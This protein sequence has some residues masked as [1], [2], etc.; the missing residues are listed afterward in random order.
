MVLIL[1][2]MIGRRESSEGLQFDL[3]VLKSNKCIN[4]PLIHVLPSIWPIGI[5]ISCDLAPL[6]SFPTFNLTY[7][8]WNEPPMRC[9]NWRTSS[10]QFDLLVLKLP[11]WKAHWGWTGLLQFDLLVLKCRWNRRLVWGFQSFNLTYWYWNVLVATGAHVQGPL[12]FDLLVLKSPW[13]WSPAPDAA[14]L[15]FDLLVLKFVKKCIAKAMKKPPSIW[16]AGIEIKYQCT[17][18]IFIGDCTDP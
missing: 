7:W 16:P 14:V 10:L 12:Q 13:T 3:L 11:S 2:H 5:E 9:R 6:Y 4:V 1:G 17:H 8:Y 18:V 15:Q